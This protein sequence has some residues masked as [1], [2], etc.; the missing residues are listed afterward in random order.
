MS[1]TPLDSKEFQKIGHEVVDQLFEFLDTIENRPLT[2]SETPLEVQ[3]SLGN[4]SLPENGEDASKLVKEITDKLV[5]HSLFNGHPGFMGYITSSALPIGALA[6][7]IASTINQNVGGWRLSPMA[8]EIER[9]S[10]QWI[11]DF[12]SYDSSCGGILVSGGNMAN[13]L[14]FLTAK[15]IK[16]GKNIQKN[17]LHKNEKQLVCYASVETHTWIQKASDLFGVGSE[18]VRWIDTNDN[19]EMNVSLLEEAIQKDSKAGFKPFLVVAT[20]GSVSFGV[21]DPLDSIHKICSKNDIWLHV[22]GA[23]GAPAAASKLAPSQ[24]GN[25]SL[26]DSIAMDPHKWLYSPLEVGCTLVKNPQHLRETF[27]HN[28]AYYEFGAQD[29]EIDYHEYGM[30]NSRGF[31]ALKV[32]MG[33]KL[34]GRKGFT[35]LIDKDISLS[36]FLF[37]KIENEKNIENYSNYLSITTFRYIPDEYISNTDTY[38]EEINELNKAILQKLFESG[39]VFVSNAYVKEM[40]LLRACLVNFR[41]SE[42]DLELLIS[43]VNKYGKEFSSK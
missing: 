13:F 16:G 5:N 27:S 31:R 30:Q 19:R 24:L 11:A 6:D 2:R 38:L 3:K 20:A 1:N 14:G 25:L 40:Y 12:I 42:E 32:W 18:F 17:G 34:L 4:K 10:I 15:T 33:F 26:A 21:V 37:E 23:Y 28:P 9:Q 39:K 22:D 36:R 43:L 8:S 35:N 41:T 29:F 7:F